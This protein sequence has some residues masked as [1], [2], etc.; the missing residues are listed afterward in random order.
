[1]ANLNEPVLPGDQGDVWDGVGL[2]PD[3]R[4]DY[5]RELIYDIA[6][7]AFSLY[8]LSHNT[9]DLSL[10]RLHDYIPIPSF[11]QGENQFDNSLI[12][13]TRRSVTNRMENFKFLATGLGNISIAEY[14]DT[15]FKDW[16]AIDGIGLDYASYLI[17]GPL[18]LNDF[19][20]KKQVSYLSTY[21][22][23]TEEQ[24]IDD[25]AGGVILDKPS[26]CITIGIWDWQSSSSKWSKWTREFQTYKL[27][28]SRLPT[29]PAVNDVL[30]YPDTVI[31]TKNLLRGR[32]R[33]LVLYFRA[34]PGKDMRLLGWHLPITQAEKV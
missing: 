23:R 5:N 22:F 27:I 32:G 26:S 31:S 28:N 13:R 8:D 7:N 12:I 14:R 29:T 21:F 11:I 3:S 20:L 1:M 18:V 6:L 9:S 10:P 4:D 33:S 16:R 30:D 34:E 15:G 2:P 24:F 25:G 19:A 17:T